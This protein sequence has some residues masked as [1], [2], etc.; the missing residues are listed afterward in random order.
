MR[1]NSEAKISGAATA[2]ARVPRTMAVQAPA[3]APRSGSI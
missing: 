2:F 3:K 1:L